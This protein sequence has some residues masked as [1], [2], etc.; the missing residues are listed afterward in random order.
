MSFW[1][2]FSDH[3]GSLKGSRLL[4]SSKHE[5]IS[6]G[7]EGYKEDTIAISRN[8]S[9]WIEGVPLCGLDFDNQI[10][11][12]GHDSVSQLGLCQP[13]EADA[14]PKIC[15]VLGWGSLMMWWPC[16]ADLLQ[17]HFSYTLECRP[18]ESYS[19]SPRL[20]FLIL[21][22][23]VEDDKFQRFLQA[24][25]RTWDDKIWDRAG[26]P[27][28]SIIRAMEECGPEY[29]QSCLSFFFFETKMPQKCVV[30]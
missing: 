24:P 21:Q 20:S 30:K 29:C 11:W 19:G 27:T 4:K 9:P 7:V 12:V 8:R 3:L 28:C 16:W 2:P 6:L 17:P 18:H 13:S 25:W 14:A 10:P 23:R 26:G 1:W 5:N 22:W 15:S